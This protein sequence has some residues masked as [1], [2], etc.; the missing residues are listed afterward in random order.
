MDTSEARQS[1]VIFGAGP[2]GLFLGEVCTRAG[3]EVLFVDVDEKPVRAI[4]ARH[5]YI[6]SVLPQDDYHTERAHEVRGVSAI[7]LSSR[8]RL[9]QAITDAQVVLTAVGIHNLKGV[10]QAMLPGLMRRLQTYGGYREGKLVVLACENAVN[11]GPDLMEYILNGVTGD[12]AQSMCTSVLAPR[13]VVDR[14]VPGLSPLEE[15]KP[16]VVNVQEY[17]KLAVEKA[18]LT[19]VTLPPIFNVSGVTLVENI[20]YEYA[21]K[22]YTVNTGHLAIAVAGFPAYR[23]IHEALEDARVNGVLDG[24]LAET[25][26][27]LALEYPV[28]HDHAGHGEYL[29]LTRERFAD[30]RLADLIGRVARNIRPKLGPEERLVK[31]A[32]ALLAAGEPVK[33]LPQVIAAGLRY[34]HATMPGDKGDLPFDE[35]SQALD[36]ICGLDVDEPLYALVRE[37]YEHTVANT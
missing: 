30:P 17:F 24:V 29:Q 35:V 33:F 14:I 21:C 8:W 23:R 9:E 7:S 18:V 31:P 22:C 13:C 19:D 20:A 32:R 26:R 6:M 3:M 11:N 28:E 34:L 1:A 12:I 15:G 36:E 16:P 25:A 5:S 37:A 2:I 27:Y 10:A 4:N